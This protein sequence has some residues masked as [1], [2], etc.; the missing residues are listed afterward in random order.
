MLERPAGNS[1]REERRDGQARMQRQRRE[2]RQ[3]RG[4]SDA[5][6]QLSWR[7]FVG[8]AAL[9]GQHH[10]SV[11]FIGSSEFGTGDKNRYFSNGLRQRRRKGERFRQ[12]PDRFS[13][14]RLMQPWI[15]WPHQRAVLVDAAESWKF[16]AM[17]ARMS[18]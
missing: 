13:E 16:F 7:F 3:G 18:S 8:N 17:P 4:R 5:V 9:L 2:P 11:D 1:V 6:R 14:L 10:V 12:L 15:P